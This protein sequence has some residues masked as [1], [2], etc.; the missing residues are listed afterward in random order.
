MFWSYRFYSDRIEIDR[1]FILS[2]GTVISLDKIEMIT[3]E[4]DPILSRLGRCNLILTFAGN[5]FTLWGLPVEIADRL[6]AQLTDSEEAEIGSVRIPAKELLKKSAMRTKLIRYLFILAI[7]WGAVFLMGSDLVD[8]RLAHTISDAVFRHLLVAGTL[9]LSLG[10]PTVLLWLWAFTGGFLLQY[11]K[12]YRYTAARRGDL[13]YFEYGFLIHR[14]IYL[15]ARRVTLVEF[16]QSPLMRAFGYGELHIRAVGHNP[17]FLKS[18]LLLPILKE[19]KLPKIMEILF[20]AIPEKPRKPCRRS[21]LYDFFSWKW[22]LPLL[23]LPLVFLF[24][25]Q[26]LIVTVA[27]ALMVTASILLEY[28]N[29]YFDLP[30]DQQTPS[31]VILSKGGFY[32]TAA[33]I[34]RERVEML[35]I[36]GSRR[37]LRRGFSNIRVKVFGKSGTYALIRNVGIDETEG[38]RTP[39]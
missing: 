30:D 5:L 32:R 26:W 31:L 4:S 29:A 34:D 15:D 14:R 17:R 6:T 36:S 9:V 3:S 24:G 22:L 11:L 39:R 21:L 23:C 38:E 16:R 25:W 19:Q 8:S 7:L 10:L 28:K 35:A 2:R 1:N 18:K 12:Y 27:I 13:L 37:K 33:W 20:P